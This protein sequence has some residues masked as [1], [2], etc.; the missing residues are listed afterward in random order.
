VDVHG[1]IAPAHV[2]ERDGEIAGQDLDRH[3][4]LLLADAVECLEASL[5]GSSAR[6]IYPELPYVATKLIRDPTRGPHDPAR[7]DHWV[8][9]RHWSGSHGPEDTGLVASHPQ[10]LEMAE[11]LMEERRRLEGAF[12]RNSLVKEDR[13]QK[14]KW[15]S[16]EERFCTLRWAQPPGPQATSE[17]EHCG[18]HVGLASEPMDRLERAF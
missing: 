13:K 2:I 3:R 10:R 4:R 11:P 17:L 9:V 7:A 5:K 16:T 15:I 6:P 18:D 8:S 1:D 14:R 12:R